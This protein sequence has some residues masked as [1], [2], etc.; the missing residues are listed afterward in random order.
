MLG[1]LG[2]AEYSRRV[3]PFVDWAQESSAKPAGDILLS[4]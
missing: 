4:S 3:D 1:A 2:N